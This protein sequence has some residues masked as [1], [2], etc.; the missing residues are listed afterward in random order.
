[1]RIGETGLIVTL[2]ESPTCSSDAVWISCRPAASC[3]FAII[4]GE[5]FR[6]AVFPDIHG[7]AGQSNSSFLSFSPGGAPGFNAVPCAGLFPRMG[8]A[9][10]SA[11]PGPRVPSTPRVQPDLFCSG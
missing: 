1:V 6:Y 10:I 8:G 9:S 7:L 11:A 4:V 3:T 5:V 2:A